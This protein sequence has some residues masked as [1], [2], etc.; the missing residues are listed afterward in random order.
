MSIEYSP[1][2]VACNIKCDYCY[3]NP[4]R[5]AGN[6][7][8]KANWP[9]AK[10]LL[11]NFNYR[12]SLHG[13]EPLLAPLVHLEEVFQFGL[14]KY[15]TNGIQTNG[16]LIT[17]EHIELFKRYNVN[18]GIS[19]DGPG[20]CNSLRRA[21]DDD[22]TAMATARTIDAI[23][24]LA[25]EG[26]IPSIIVTVHKLNASDIAR[27]KIM[28]EWFSWLESYGIKY[29]NLHMLET[30]KGMENLALSE[31]ENTE[32]FL[33]FYEFSK[34]SKMHIIP[35]AD[36]REL[37]TV[38]KTG[39]CIWNGCDPY[40]TTAVNGVSRS[41]Q[42]SNC[43]RMNKEGVNWVKADT[44]TRERNL[45][46]FHT[47]QEYGGCKDCRFF[48][49]CKGNCPGTAIDGDWRNR[50]VHCA[51]WFAL[52]EAIEKEIIEPISHDP[53]KLDEM[54]HML[55]NQSDHADSPHIDTHGDSDTWGVP[56][57]WLSV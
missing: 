24:T 56:V 22:E 26:L 49:F 40:T 27:R 4:M 11:S 25:Q 52:F 6:I 43:G 42:R 47:P 57:T 2:D 33:H 36:I 45:V 12:F 10:E 15:G 19:I 53:R 9:K 13:G 54:T 30:E 3:E 8:S 32:A 50:T 21:H 17:G 5:D 1:V 7:S 28:I 39:M 20:S 18:V 29:L 23:K 55:I 51:T 48:V 31:E 34:T 35:F 38:G 44:T 16:T 41:G 14:E 46:L 37:L